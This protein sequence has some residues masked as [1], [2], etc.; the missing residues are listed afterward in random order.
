MKSL[1]GLILGRYNYIP[2]IPP[3]AMP[4]YTTRNVCLFIVYYVHCQVA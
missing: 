4:L 2:D 3:V 1:L